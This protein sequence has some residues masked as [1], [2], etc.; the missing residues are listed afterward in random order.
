[1]HR[2]AIKLKD[3]FAL[4]NDEPII[5]NSRWHLL[6]GKIRFIETQ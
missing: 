4:A 5:K 2:I 6:Y 3:V 1:M